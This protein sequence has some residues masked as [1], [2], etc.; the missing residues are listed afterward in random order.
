MSG[1][2]GQK[3]SLLTVIELGD[4]CAHAGLTIGAVAYSTLSIYFATRNG[5][6]AT[7]VC[8]AYP[9]K[10]RCFVYKT[11]SEVVYDQAYSRKRRPRARYRERF[12]CIG[13]WRAPVSEPYMCAEV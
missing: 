7:R 5:N 4:I 6:L 12:G 2:K 13:E 11:R 8:T 1:N 3:R 9:P 10:K